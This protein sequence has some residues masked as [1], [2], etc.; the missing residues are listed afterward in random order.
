[1]RESAIGPDAAGSDVREILS[2]LRMTVAGGY[3]SHPSSCVIE[4]NQ[5]L[6]MSHMDQLE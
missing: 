4:A 1:M 2:F 5:A 3:G 6:A